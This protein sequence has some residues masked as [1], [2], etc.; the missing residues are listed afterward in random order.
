MRPALLE[1]EADAA[2]CAVKPRAKSSK[3]LTPARDF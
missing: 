3:L 2:P 1:A